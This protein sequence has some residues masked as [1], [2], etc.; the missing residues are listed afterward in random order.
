MASLSTAEAAQYRDAGYVIPSFRLADQ[1]VQQ[2]RVSL[3]RLI[4]DN[5]DVRPEKLVSAH[6]VGH[7]GAPNIEGVRGHQDFLDLANDPDLRKNYLGL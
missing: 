2:L 6:V 3:E 7:N 5:P 1:R 4:R